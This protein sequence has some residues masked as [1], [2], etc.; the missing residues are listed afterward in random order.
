MRK[1]SSSFSREFIK[2]LM[3][4]CVWKQNFDLKD[5]LEKN[6]LH[7][8]IRVQGSYNTFS[9]GFEYQK[10]IELL[11]INL[12]KEYKLLNV[13]LEKNLIISPDFENMERIDLVWKFSDMAGIEPFSDGS[14]TIGLEKLGKNNVL[15][16]M[17]FF[18]NNKKD[19]SRARGGAWYK[20]IIP[21]ENSYYIF[22]FDYA[23]KTSKEFP[24]FYLGKGIKEIRIQHTNQKWIKVIFILNNLSGEFK[25]LKPLI[26]IWGTGSML[27]DN[28][29]LAKVINPKLSI[30]KD[31]IMFVK[32]NLGARH[33]SNQ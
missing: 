24:S 11:S 33:T 8:K 14:F 29:F 2:N 31:N 25:F 9:T 10:S 16:I 27:V 5:F 12:Q 6:M 4:F 1:M 23:T 28:I 21:I 32:G 26:R 30:S 15:R 22:S 20:G 19:K 3:D 17:G 7:N 13:L 18:I